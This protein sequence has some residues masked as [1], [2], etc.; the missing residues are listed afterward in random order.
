MTVSW[1]GWPTSGHWTLY[2]RGVSWLCHGLDDPPQATEH[3]IIEVR[4]DCVMVWMTHLRPLNT[5][6]QRCIMTVSWSGWPTSGHWTLYYRGAS[7]LCHGL[8]DPPQATEHFIIEVCHGLDHPPQATE[9]FIIEVC[10]DWFVCKDWPQ[11]QSGLPTL[12]CWAL[13]PS[14]VFPLK[15][16]M[17]TYKIWR[18]DC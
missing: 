4:H 7:W 12:G 6:L 18:G 3:F 14:E 16:F 15:S 11:A 13:G 9:H 1:S 8:D 2:Y 5:L 17:C 10:H